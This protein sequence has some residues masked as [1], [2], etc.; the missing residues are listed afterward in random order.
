MK[1]KIQGDITLPVLGSVFD[2]ACKEV[3]FDPSKHV[4]HGCTLYF[5]F[6]DIETGKEIILRDSDGQLCDA[7]GYVTPDEQERLRQA[8]IAR[9]QAKTAM[10][11]KLV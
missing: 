8:A 1:L 11:K 6:H 7:L 5:N 2:K 9:K 3:S 10:T 4:V